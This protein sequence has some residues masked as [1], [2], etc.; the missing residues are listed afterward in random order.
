MKFSPTKIRSCKEWKDVLIKLGDNDLYFR[1]DYIRATGFPLLPKEVLKTLAVNLKGKNVIDAGCGTGF[2]S[3]LLQKQG[4]NVIPVDNN[5]TDH[6]FKAEAY[7]DIV[8]K[9]AVSC[10][11]REHDVVILSW[12]YYKGS[13]SLDV[14]EAMHPGQTMIYQGEA[15]GNCTGTYEFFDCLAAKFT[16]N[17]PFTQELNHNHVQFRG[18]HDYW[19]VYEK[20]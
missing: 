15:K 3:W 19:E 11:S 14:C 5:E 7:T 10:I 2:L 1:R 12:P 9:D 8:K 16:L 17:L 6:W 18:F 20:N 4:I 13:F